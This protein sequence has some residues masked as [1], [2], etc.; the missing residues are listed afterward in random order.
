[1]G[2]PNRYRLLIIVLLMLMASHPS[3]ALVSLLLM[4]VSVLNVSMRLTRRVCSQRHPA[5]L[6]KTSTLR[7]ASFD[8]RRSCMGWWCPVGPMCHRRH[9]RLPMTRMRQRKRLIASTRRASQSAMVPQAFPTRYSS[10]CTR[11]RTRPYLFTNSLRLLSMIMSNTVL[12]APGIESACNCQERHLGRG[13]SGISQE[14][15]EVVAQLLA[16][17]RRY[18][19]FVN[20]DVV[21]EWKEMTKKQMNALCACSRGAGPVC[22]HRFGAIVNAALSSLA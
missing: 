1:M 2:R 9:R 21:A 12:V 4:I 16:E 14:G 19:A 5:R 18:T 10:S 15:Q 11:R 7:H 17:G 20:V 22:A 13:H 3:V 8:P 6:R